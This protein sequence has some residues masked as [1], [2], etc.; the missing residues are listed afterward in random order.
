MT[1]TNPIPYSQYHVIDEDW[2]DMDLSPPLTP[3]ERAGYSAAWYGGLGVPDGWDAYGR[4]REGNCWSKTYTHL[5]QLK[6][7]P[8]TFKV[9]PPAP[10]KQRWEY[11]RGPL[12]PRPRW[13]LDT[14]LYSHDRW[15]TELHSHNRWEREIK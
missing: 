12:G 15:E 13:K 2:D 5:P 1:A 8:K 10:P 11:P 7:N 3:G 9:G 4:R 14:E 6:R